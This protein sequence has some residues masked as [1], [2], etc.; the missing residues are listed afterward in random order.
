MRNLEESLFWEIFYRR[1]VVRSEL[2]QLFNVS[3]ATISRSAGALLSRRLI[4]ETGVT[5][6][7][8]GRR[9]TLLQINPALA[10]VAGVEIDRDRIT[11][12]VTDMAG[13][14]LGRGATG[15]SSRHPMRRTLRDC[16]TAVRI[17]VA[18]ANPRG[19][20]LSRIGVGHTGTLDVENGVCMDWE[21]VP[22][23]RR[24]NLR[25]A[26][27]ETFDLGVTLDDRARTV[28]LAQHL[29]WP[30]HPR[31]RSAIYVQIGSGTGAGI[32]VH[33]R[34]LPRSLAAKS[35]IR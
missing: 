9:P 21:G 33:G 12:V 24:V 11:A 17:A 23:W 30:E 1:Q 25:A 35:G 29:L 31:Y 32:F 34:M 27:R 26:L 2:A 13:N 22:H 19:C 20:R 10:H 4:V 18:D 8:R 15:A 3:A 16:R 28:A 14:L 5:S 7:S 6:S